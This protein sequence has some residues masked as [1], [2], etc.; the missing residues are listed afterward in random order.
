MEADWAQ[1]LGKPVIS[2]EIAVI[3]SL[4]LG[5]IG[6]LSGIFPSRRAASVDPVESL[7]YE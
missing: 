3:T 1:W 2:L 7:R 6:M 5:I 4:I